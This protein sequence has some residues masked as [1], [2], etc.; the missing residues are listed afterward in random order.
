MGSEDYTRAREK[1]VREQILGRGIRDPRVIEA[2]LKV[3]R[4]LFVPEALVGDAKPSI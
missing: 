3:P 2:L 4:H 1:M